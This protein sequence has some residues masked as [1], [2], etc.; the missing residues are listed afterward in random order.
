MENVVLGR[1]FVSRQYFYSLYGFKKLIYKKY[2]DKI[3]DE[4]AKI[5]FKVRKEIKNGI[6]LHESINET[7]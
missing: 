6:R 1:H 3:D 2:E 5:I 7:R 4:S